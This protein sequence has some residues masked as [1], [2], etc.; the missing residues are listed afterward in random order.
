MTSFNS[1]MA[2]LH[3]YSDPIFLF[4]F[5]QSTGKLEYTFFSTLTAN[6]KGPMPL[7]D[8]HLWAMLSSNSTSCKMSQSGRLLNHNLWKLCIPSI[9]HMRIELIKLQLSSC[10]YLICLYDVRWVSIMKSIYRTIDLIVCDLKV[11]RHVGKDQML[12]LHAPYLNTFITILFYHIPVKVSAILILVYT[13]VCFSLDAKTVF[14]L[15]LWILVS[16]FIM[17]SL[18]SNTVCQLTGQC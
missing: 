3:Y 1:H 6:N 14:F 2:M 7:G 5:S 11:D 8:V 18:F 12:Y 15:C 16:R 4:R 17:F 13:M 10:S 9:L